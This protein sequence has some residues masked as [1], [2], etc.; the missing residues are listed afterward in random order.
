VSHEFDAAPESAVAQPAAAPGLRAMPGLSSPAALRRLQQTAGNAAIARRIQRD[1]IN[2]E[3]SNPEPDKKETGTVGELP[4]GRDAL[5]ALDANERATNVHLFPAVAMK[6]KGSE[7]APLVRRD[8]KFPGWPALIDYPP[9]GSTDKT[10]FADF[11]GSE[12]PDSRLMLTDALYIGGSPRMEE[13]QQG[14]VGDCWDLAVVGA[15]VGKDPGKIMSMM[16]KTP[17]GVSVTF[18][19]RKTKVE[20]WPPAIKHVWE[21]VTVSTSYELPFTVDVA[22]RSTATV[23]GNRA[24]QGSQLYRA[25][26]PL[27][28]HWWVEITGS[29]A[30]IRSKSFYE[31]A[32]WAPLLE[33]CF[34]MFAAKYGQYGGTGEDGEKSGGKGFDPLQGGREKDLFGVFY[35][36]AGDISMHPENVSSVDTAFTPGGNNLTNNVPAITQLLPLQGLPD[37]LPPGVGASPVPLVTA[38]TSSETMLTRLRETLTRLMGQPNWDATLSIWT[39]E[40]IRTMADL[41]KQRAEL[42]PPAGSK[43]AELNGSEEKSNHEI[44]GQARR[45]L[46]RHDGDDFKELRTDPKLGG[47][48]TA[49]VELLFDVMN[50]GKDHGSGMRS[51]YPEHAYTVISVKF[52]DTAGKPVVLPPTLPANKAELDQALA[53]VSDQQSTVRLRN[54]HHANEPDEIGDNQ[55]GRSGSGDNPNDGLFNMSLASFLLSTANVT[56]FKAPHSAPPAP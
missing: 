40:R 24:I 6:A 47:D 27:D 50:I 21:P 29:A 30:S 32:R 46:D 8:T 19:H 9:K 28:K 17:T 31:A 39:K 34:A 54:P 42:W 7:A 37:Q 3:P 23:N 43:G 33:K 51:L 53:P 45:T 14:M 10:G 44:A 12:Q 22:G 35:G 36:E 18:F 56:S 15:I 48:V 13:I 26:Q 49:I 20:L 1:A 11:D 4:E 5:G 16:T 38:A 2:G 55:T 41:L 25:A 52:A